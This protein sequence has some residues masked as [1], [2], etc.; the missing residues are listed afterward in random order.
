[1]CFNNHSDNLKDISMNQYWTHYW[2]QPCLEA[3]RGQAG[4]E[5][6]HTAGNQFRI[7]GVSDGDFVYCLSAVAGS[8]IL[9]ARIKIHDKI[10]SQQ[11]AD[12]YFGE[13]VWT[14]TDH[15]IALPGNG[16]IQDYDRE[17]PMNVLRNLRFITQKGETK[18]K[19]QG[20]GIDQQA[21][22]QVR[23][24]TVMSARLLDKIINSTE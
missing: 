17:V 8:V 4:I 6:I 9:I 2:T 5:L 1:V 11:E 19:F 14:A 20:D 23:Q 18:I 15:L 22:R 13:P 24:L 10:R 7:R 21:L 16:S 3:H 12:E